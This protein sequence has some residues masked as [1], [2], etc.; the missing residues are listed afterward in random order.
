[1]PTYAYECSGCNQIFELRHAMDETVDQC[2]V[3]LHKPIV[4][5]PSSFLLKM[6]QSKQDMLSQ[7]P[8]KPG[9]VV[10]STIEESRK[11]IAEEKE[12]LKKR[13]WEPPK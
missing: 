5:K 7:M 11:D 10:T 9:T 2:P 1:M 13:M 6:E 8:V 12:N 4:K 3:C